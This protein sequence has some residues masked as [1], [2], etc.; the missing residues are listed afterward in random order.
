[1]IGKEE[2]INIVQDFMEQDQ[3]VNDLRKLFDT[4]WDN[5][6]IEY[7]LNVFDKLIRV[8]FNKDGIYWIWYYIDENPS[9]CYYVDDRKIPLETLDDLWETIKGYRI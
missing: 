4:G 3:R 7:G 6:L 8:Y 2:F 9:K 1:M 5:P